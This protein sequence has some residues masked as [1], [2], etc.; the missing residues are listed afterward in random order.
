M[1]DHSAR[2]TAQE[3]AHT[4]ILFPDEAHT[5]T[6]WAN[7]DLQHAVLE[8]FLVDCLHGASAPLT[9]A[10]RNASSARFFADSLGLEKDTP[11]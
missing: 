9:V 7:A 3:R 1:E 8:R 5:T 11:R 10:E 2:L 4:L 6:K